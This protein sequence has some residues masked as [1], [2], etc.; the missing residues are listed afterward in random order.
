MHKISKIVL[1]ALLSL[2]NILPMIAQASDP[3]DYKNVR[4]GDVVLIDLNCYVCKIIKDE[5]SSEY[6][7]S[8][9]VI[10]HNGNDYMVAQSLGKTEILSLNEFLGLRRKNSSVKVIRP[11][12]LEI[13]AIADQYEFESRVK[14]LQTLYYNKYANTKFDPLFLWDNYDES[15]DEILYCSEM[16]TKLLNDILGKDIKTVPMTFDKNWDHWVEYYGEM[17]PPQGKPGTSPGSLERDPV[18]TTINP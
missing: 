2:Y 13:L 5:T 9:L 16:I 3:L 14:L 7:H 11:V 15:G 12:E 6:S 10:G 4:P 17:E 1:V 18:F 8:G